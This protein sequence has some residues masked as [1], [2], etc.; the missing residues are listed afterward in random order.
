[1]TDGNVS[2]LTWELWEKEKLRQAGVALKIDVDFAKRKLE[3][4]VARGIV[5]EKTLR[6]YR[7]EL[8]KAEAA[9]VDYVLAHK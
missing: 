8:R 9:L 7:R 4:A 1:M 6:R 2:G 5:S 3:L